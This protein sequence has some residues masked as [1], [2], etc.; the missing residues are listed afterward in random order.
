VDAVLCVRGACPQQL[1][2]RTFGH[3][4]GNQGSLATVVPHAAT[5]TEATAC[6]Y[7]VYGDAG[8]FDTER[9]GHL[10]SRGIGRLGGSP[11]LCPVTLDH[12]R[13]A[14]RLHRCVAEIG[15][16]VVGAD[17]TCRTGQGRVHITLVA[18]QRR[19][20]VGLEASGENGAQAVAIHAFV[21]LRI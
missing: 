13:G 6:L 14:H 1:D 7:T 19:C 2:G 10:G 12:Y 21:A 3:G 16:V 18:R 20:V 4:S 17:H 9:T 15:C 5:T 11:D 8:G